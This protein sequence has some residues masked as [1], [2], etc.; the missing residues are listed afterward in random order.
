VVLLGQALL[1]SGNQIPL[2]LLNEALPTSQSIMLQGLKAEL[3]EREA[4]KQ[5]QYKNCYICYTNLIVMDLAA[6]KYRLIERLTNLMSEEKLDK[7]EKFLNKE[8]FKDNE[9][10]LTQDIKDLLDER[11]A[12]HKTNPKTGK[13]WEAIKSDLAQ[14][15]A[16]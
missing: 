3:I 5:L 15:Y 13:S 10:I 6:R 8:I 2:T 11:L 9:P 7:I 12:K 14:K 4:I 16:S 1:L